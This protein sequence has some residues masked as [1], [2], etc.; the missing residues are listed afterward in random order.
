ME[1]K[2]FLKL[3]FSA[4]VNKLKPEYSAHEVHKMKLK[5]HFIASSFHNNVVSTIKKTLL[6]SLHIGFLKTNPR[7]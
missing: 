5:G 4:P 3:N 6:K 2:I 7:S 1:I